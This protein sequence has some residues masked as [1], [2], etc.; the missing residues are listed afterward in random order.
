MQTPT[1]I[2]QI[3]RLKPALTDACLAAISQGLVQILFYQRGGTLQRELADDVNE[4]VLQLLAAGSWRRV[5]SESAPFCGSRGCARSNR[6]CGVRRS[7]AT[8]CEL[9]NS[10]IWPSPILVN[11]QN[12]QISCDRNTFSKPAAP[13]SHHGGSGRLRAGH[14]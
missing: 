8:C 9:A 14:R 10:G 5:T 2:R 6:D 7:L 3:L 1:S 13:Q 11:S 12:G 4:L